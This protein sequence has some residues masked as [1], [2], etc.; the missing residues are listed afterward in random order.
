[1]MVYKRVD[2]PFILNSLLFLKSR[3]FI[4]FRL[5][6]TLNTLLINRSL[7]DHSQSLSQ[8]VG[9][10]KFETFESDSAA[11]IH[12]ESS[13]PLPS[14]GPRAAPLS[15]SHSHFTQAMR[16]FLNFLL[17]TLVLAASALAASS[18]SSSSSISITTEASVKVGSAIRFQW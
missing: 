13:S 7:P 15:L 5:S 14:S 1:M 18:S 6:L 10:R 4:S 2:S 3:F 12:A 8:T 16:I 17:S 11:T 9:S